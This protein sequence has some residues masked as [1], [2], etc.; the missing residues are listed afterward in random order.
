[1]S[2]PPVPLA[3]G[4][5]DIGVGSQS[6]AW[7]TF[8]ENSGSFLL[9][10]PCLTPLFLSVQVLSFRLSCQYLHFRSAVLHCKE[11]GVCVVSSVSFVL[12][13]TYPFF[14]CQREHL[15]YCREISNIRNNILRL[16]I[17]LAFSPPF[18]SIFFPSPLLFFFASVFARGYSSTLSYIFHY[19]LSFKT[20]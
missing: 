7:W 2:D 16:D 20:V 19:L 13:S 11:M 9:Q 14:G 4:E 18:L 6:S 1:M 5:V 10:I 12:N 17:I 15:C 8:R 3:S